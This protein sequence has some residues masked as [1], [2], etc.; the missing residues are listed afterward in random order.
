MISVMIHHGGDAG[1]HVVQAA[2]QKV[3][4]LYSRNDIEITV[5]VQIANSSSSRPRHAIQACPSATCEG[6]T[7]TTK[8][9]KTGASFSDLLCST[10]YKVGWPLTSELNESTSSNTSTSSFPHEHPP[11]SRHHGLFHIHHHLCRG[12]LRVCPRQRGEWRKWRLCLLRCC[13]RYSYNSI[14]ERFMFCAAHPASLITISF[15]PRVN[16]NSFL[17]FLCRIVSL[18]SLW[19]TYPY[20]S[21]SY[22]GVSA[23]PRGS[24]W[25][26][27]EIQVGTG[28]GED[29][30]SPDFLGFNVRISNGWTLPPLVFQ[31]AKVVRRA[32]SQTEAAL[33]EAWIDYE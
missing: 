27:V 17:R 2:N 11:H 10:G 29:Q 13:L 23:G 22:R 4:G 28:T 19:M 21:A 18:W 8:K 30:A 5:I 7:I 12:H 15:I 26:S 14:L 6:D 31:P 32:R 16:F 20:V 25:D 1:R 24:Y 9:N 3:P 33:L